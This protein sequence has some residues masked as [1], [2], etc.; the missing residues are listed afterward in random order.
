MFRFINFTNSRIFYQVLFDSPSLSGSRRTHNCR[1]VSSH[2]Q[3]VSTRLYFI[4]TCTVPR[5]PRIT[6]TVLSSPY[7][8]TGRNATRKRSEWIQFLELKVFQNT[9]KYLKIPK[10][11][12]K[13]SDQHSRLCKSHS[14]ER[15]VH[16][17]LTVANPPP[18]SRAMS[19]SEYN[20]FAVSG[21]CRH[22]GSASLCF[23]IHAVQL[24]GCAH[25]AVMIAFCSVYR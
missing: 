25:Y 23:C 9:E 10:D 20:I 21:V 1:L 16:W 7:S 15:N 8:I 13:F 22:W 4:T 2:L 14:L 17:E 19:N 6:L 12:L 3:K 11:F 18:S 24:A 5:S